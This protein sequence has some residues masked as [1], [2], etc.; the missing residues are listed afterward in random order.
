MAKNNFRYPGKAFGIGANAIEN[1]MCV[2]PDV[3]KVS[4][5][6]EKIYLG[7]TV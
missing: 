3:T 7:T 6:G 2:V 4:Y 1:P 5:P